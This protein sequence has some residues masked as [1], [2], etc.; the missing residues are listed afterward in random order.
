[1]ILLV[2]PMSLAA[3]CT[4]SVMARRALDLFG[5]LRIAPSDLE[6]LG[7]GLAAVGDFLELD[8]LTFIER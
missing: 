6:V 5:E 1:M 8:G 4:Q 3:E 2:E 7:R